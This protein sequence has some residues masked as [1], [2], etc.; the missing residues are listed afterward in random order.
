MK[1][2]DNIRVDIF[3]NEYLIKGE[4]DPAY[5]KDLAKYVDGKMREITQTTSL[6]TSSKVAI[7]TALN[8]ADE[9]FRL[10]RSKETPATGAD[11]K[12]DELVKRIDEELK[13]MVPLL[14]ENI[15][16]SLNITLK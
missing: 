16:G 2:S 5:I 11:K 1:M 3:G 8:I 15:P 10:K 7:L 12:I 4:A 14:K 6:V 9:L 13:G